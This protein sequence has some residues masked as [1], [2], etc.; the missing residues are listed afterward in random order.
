ML[1]PLTTQLV[2]SYAKP[3]WL[4]RPDRA[5]GEPDGWWRPDPGV[6]PE[7]IAD[8]TRLAVFDQE[9]AGLDLV[10]DGEQG[11]QDYGRHLPARLTGVDA[12]AYARE[13]RPAPAR[14]WVAYNE[15]WRAAGNDR[16]VTAPRIVGPI[17]WPGPLGLEEVRFLKRQTRRP[18]K[19]TLPGPMTAAWFLIDEHYGDPAAATMALAAALN[20]EMRALAAEGVDLVQID[21]PSI[22]F[23]LQGFLNY[24]AAALEQM[25]AGVPGPI[26]VHVCYGYAHLVERKTLDP[27]YG[28]GLEAL[29]GCAIDAI[30][31]EYE[32]PGHGPELLARCGDKHVI[33]GL[34]NLGTE[35]AE[36]PEQVARRLR[37]ALEVVP[38]ERLHPA[39]DCGMWH[40]PRAV[41][42]AKL[43]ALV[44]GTEI[45][46]RERV[47]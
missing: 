31:L 30:S 26:A 12:T 14:A 1:R 20:R 17:G 37:A 40:L 3:R 19:Y 42:F 27:A 44:L 38:A 5:F 13:E 34:L 11:R 22:H 6:L 21:E 35:E 33:L 9:R 24:G 43:R 7:A 8:A 2:G 10:T 25:V 16:A 4:V 29:A 15:A 47:S 39:P 18:V 45:V 46:R 41:A 32:Q 36:S 28:D 23:N